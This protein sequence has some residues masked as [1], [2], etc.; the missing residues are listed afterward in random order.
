MSTGCIFRIRDPFSNTRFRFFLFDISVVLGNIFEVRTLNPGIHVAR[1][2]STLTRSSWWGATAQ[3]TART[4]RG[5]IPY[6]YFS[7]FNDFFLRCQCFG[8][9][10]N[11][12]RI[13]KLTKVFYSLFFL[14]FVVEQKYWTKKAK[15]L[16][17]PYIFV[18]YRYRYRIFKTL[19]R[20]R[21]LLSSS[22][23][24]RK[25]LDFYFFVTSLWL[26]IFEELNKCTVNK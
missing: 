4:R 16:C 11:C 1:F 13:Q 7:E 10:L 25:N 21:I 24:S 15:K 5:E 26:F 18:L 8:S 9:R 22:K 2:T 3:T 20:I 17:L 19:F 23:N 6:T 12:I 14:R